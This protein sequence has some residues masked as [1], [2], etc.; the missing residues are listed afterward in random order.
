MLHKDGDA[1]R[2]YPQCYS[3]RD[4][5]LFCTYCPLPC[6]SLIVLHEDGDTVRLN[7]WYSTVFT[8][9]VSILHLL[10]VCFH[11]R[12][13]IN[14]EYCPTVRLQVYFAVA[15]GFSLIVKD[16]SFISVRVDSSVLAGL[17][18]SVLKI[19]SSSPPHP[20]PPPHTHT[21]R[22][23][24]SLHPRVPINKHIAQNVSCLRGKSKSANTSFVFC[25]FFSSLYRNC[26]SDIGRETTRVSR[27]S[28]T[29]AR[30]TLSGCGRCAFSHG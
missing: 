19:Y 28:S 2:Q 11:E 17:S 21:D 30:H 16:V 20:P 7:P 22:E 9:I 14:A 1:V 15:C 29:R 12:V 27:A 3:V 5:S 8:T 25:L 24:H 26:V 23:T 6:A 13:D 10:S 4:F 18:V